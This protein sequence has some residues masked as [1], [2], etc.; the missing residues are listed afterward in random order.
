[1]Q[2]RL[3][4][5]SQ[6]IT[7][8][9]AT[10]WN[11]SGTEVGWDK[12]SPSIWLWALRMNISTACLNGI[13]TLYN[14]L[15]CKKQLIVTHEQG[16]PSLGLNIHYPDSVKRLK[17]PKVPINVKKA[18]LDARYEAKSKKK[19]KRKRKR[20]SFEPQMHRGKS[21]ANLNRTYHG[22]ELQ[23]SLF[24]HFINDGCLK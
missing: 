9:P 18:M 21:I 23:E 12:G 8:D 22:N 16:R 17:W 7:L 3:T 13:K 2:E 10:Y 14:K 5:L 4:N 6:Q 11:K 20:K 19:R 1:M 15:C 24:V